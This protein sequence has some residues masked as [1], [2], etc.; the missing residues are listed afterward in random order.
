MQ[1]ER[2]LADYVGLLHFKNK[3]KKQQQKENILGKKP[4]KSLA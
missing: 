3:N 2:K 1:P 4:V